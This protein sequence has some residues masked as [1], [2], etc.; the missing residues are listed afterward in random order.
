MTDQETVQNLLSEIAHL[1]FSKF[2]ITSPSDG[3]FHITP[4]KSIDQQRIKDFI[5][6][7]NEPLGPEGI[8]PATAALDGDSIKVSGINYEQLNFL[9]AQII[10]NTPYQLPLTISP[11]DNEKRILDGLDFKIVPACTGIWTFSNNPHILQ[12]RFN[13]PDKELGSNLL[14]NLCDG[15]NSDYARFVVVKKEPSPPVIAL[16]LINDPDEFRL[17]I[18]SDDIKNILNNFKISAIKIIE[19]YKKD[20]MPASHKFMPGTL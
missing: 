1:A 15:L 13:F 12:M 19:E 2:N 4:H 16:T 3:V 14:A 17:Y 18:E 20:Y 7:L 8:A 6:D 10:D 9:H 5:D 11:G